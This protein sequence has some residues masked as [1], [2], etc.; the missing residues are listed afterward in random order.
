MEFGSWA[1]PADAVEVSVCYGE[2][3]REDI[4]EAVAQVVDDDYIIARFQEFEYCVAADET[5]S[6]GDEYK[7]FVVREGRGYIE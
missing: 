2:N 3:S 1:V 5:E 7:L 4:V 6:A